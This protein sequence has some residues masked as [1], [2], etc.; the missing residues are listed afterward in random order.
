MNA[1]LAKIYRYPVKGLSADPLTEVVL[2]SGETLPEDRRFAITHG[3]SNFDPNMPG[4][5]P[6]HNFLMLSRN[7]RLAALETQYDPAT[8]TLTIRRNGRQVARGRITTPTGRMLIDEFFAAYM[9][10]QGPGGMPHLVE[11]PGH[12]FSDTREKLVSIVGTASVQDLERVVHVPVD[13]RRFRANLLIEGL[14]PWAE[15]KWI[16]RSIR[17]GVARL[18]IVEPISRCAATNVDPETGVR[19]L[20]LL[21]ALMRGYG[22]DR[23]GVYAR[24]VDS[25]RIALGDSVTVLD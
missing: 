24:V 25:G 15:Q 17:I 20:N 18:E 6:K 9:K 22:H 23:C 4:W 16:G 2:E 19:D 11:A 10:G 1:S 5:L 12:S 14:E 21:Q 3:A 7:E 8:G 13:P